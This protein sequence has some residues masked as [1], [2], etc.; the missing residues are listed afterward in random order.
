MNRFTVRRI[1]LSV[2]SFVFIVSFCAGCAGK[3]GEEK[4]SMSA[5][6]PTQHPLKQPANNEKPDL[7][8]EDNKYKDVKI[9]D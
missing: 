6:V 5:V 1:F 8:G 3:P 2:L 7:L 4:T 9:Y